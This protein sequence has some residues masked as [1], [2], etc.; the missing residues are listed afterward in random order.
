MLLS[1]ELLP[2]KA[3][4]P[5]LA[6]IPGVSRIENESPGLPYGQPNLQDKSDFEP[7]R[8]CELKSCLQMY[9]N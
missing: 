9:P 4:M 8:H 3:Y 2:V 5:T 1:V 6:D 7:L